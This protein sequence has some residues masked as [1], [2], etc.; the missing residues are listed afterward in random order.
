MRWED[1]RARHPSA[2]LIIEA[3]QAHSSSGKRILD[4][5]SVVETCDGGAIAHRRYRELHAAQPERELYFVHTSNA[6]LDIEELPWVG[7]RWDD[8]TRSPQ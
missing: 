5:I 4:Q 8:A 2:W 1:V 3:T 7:I 6:V